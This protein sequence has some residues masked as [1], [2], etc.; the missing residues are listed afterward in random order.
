MGSDGVRMGHGMVGTAYEI[1]GGKKHRESAE[2]WQVEHQEASGRMGWRGRMGS[3]PW[4][5]VPKRS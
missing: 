1:L 5:T 2:S 3:V 4:C